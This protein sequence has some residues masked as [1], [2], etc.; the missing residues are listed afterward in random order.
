MA[1]TAELFLGI[2]VGTSGVRLC[3]I[4]GDAAV[5]AEAQERMPA[6]E[7]SGAAVQQN[8]QIWWEALLAA[9]ATL[10]RA[11]EMKRVR[12]IAVDGTSGTLLLIDPRGRPLTPGLMYNDARARAEAARVAEVAPPD[13]ATPTGSAPAAPPA[14]GS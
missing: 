4:D 9:L 8:P 12:R 3:A 10:G 7:R 13:P 1:A 14:G 5:V 11:V 2:D 6:P